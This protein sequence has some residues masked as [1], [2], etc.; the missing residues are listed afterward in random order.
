MNKRGRPS[1]ITQNT[2]SKLESAFSYGCSDREAC[3]LADIGEQTL[4]DYQNKNP[5]F[6][7]RKELLKS[8]PIL[9]ARMT[10]VNNLESDANLAFKYLERRKR[11]E[12]DPRYKEVNL[13]RRKTDND[14]TD[15][16]A[17]AFEDMLENLFQ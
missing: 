17:E 9:K 3:L 13:E 6:K 8:K 2:I 5:E 15:E 4:Y 12:F 10:V 16:E 1:K 11:D 7:Q 14:L